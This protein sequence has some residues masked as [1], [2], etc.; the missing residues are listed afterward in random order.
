M[1][2][3]LANTATS[4]W[5]PL[6]LYLLV[7]ADAFVVVLPSET[8][9]VALGSLALSTGSPTLA[10][11]I[12]VAT[13]GAITGDTLCYLIGRRI[14]TERSWMR[15]PRIAAAIDRARRTIAT[16]PATLI[17]TARYIPFARIA[18][19][20]TAGSTGFPFRRYLPIASAA[21][22]GWAIYNSIIGALFGAWL[23]PWPALAIVAAVVVAMALGISIDVVVRAV[24][25]GRAATDDD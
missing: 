6:V 8:F 3:W 13:L 2:A 4:P 16:R 14:G 15:R 20:L 9:V 7:V 10:V 21:G 11:I 19:N 24:S 1:D 17:V 18:V 22:L 25:R 5:L 12:P 23:A